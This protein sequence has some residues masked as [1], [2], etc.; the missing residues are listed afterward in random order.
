MIGDVPW[1]Q[2]TCNGGNARAMGAMGDGRAGGVGNEQCAM[3]EKQAVQYG[4]V[5]YGAT[6]RVEE[7]RV[8]GNVIV[9]K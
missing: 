2:R 5:T 4:R 8:S 3:C 9:N 1:G 6:G 7:L